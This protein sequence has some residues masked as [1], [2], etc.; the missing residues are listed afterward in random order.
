MNP[1]QRGNMRIELRDYKLAHGCVV[2]G[3]R[4]NPDG[5]NFDHRDERT[6]S[7]NLADFGLHSVTDVRAELAKV[8]V[9]CGTHH[10]IRSAERNRRFNNGELPRPN[11]GDR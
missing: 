10:L 1:H 3:Y 8:D 11:G 4:E 5:L 7:F 6:K 9:I 2:C